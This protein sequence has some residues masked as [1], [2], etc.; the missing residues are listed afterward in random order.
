M[1]LKNFNLLGL[2][3]VAV[4]VLISCI[5]SRTVA[6]EIT[7][8]G[9]CGDLNCEQLLAQLK[10]NWSEQ[11]S[12]YTAE[13]QSGKNLGLNVWNRNES[14]VVTLICWGD[15]DPNGEIYGTSLGLLPFPGDEENFT[16]KW[17]CWNSDECKNALIK[18][19][20]QYPEEIRKYEVECA[21]ESGELTLVI[22]QVNG[23][24]EAN[25]QCSF[26]VPNTQID[27]NGDG[28]ADG[29]VAKPTSV[30]ITLGT[31]TLPQ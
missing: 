12:Q 25:V 2:V 22:P 16:S 24:S 17:N 10:S 6:G 29:A 13:C 8:S 20:D 23:L 11:I 27:D 15:K 31:L 26:F 7:V 19:R 28:V 1:T 18:L 14:K 21:M 3:T 30:D 9:N 4:P 5:Y